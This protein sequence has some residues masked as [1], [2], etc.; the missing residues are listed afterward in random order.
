MPSSALAAALNEVHACLQVAGALQRAHDR[1][2]A[3]LLAQPL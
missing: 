1:G 2:G 3:V